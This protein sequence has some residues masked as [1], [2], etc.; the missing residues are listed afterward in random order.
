MNFTFN[1]NIF[2]LDANITFGNVDSFYVNTTQDYIKI[3]Y[4]SN[5]GLFRFQGETDEEVYNEYY[6]PTGHMKLK[7]PA[8][9]KFFGK[10]IYDVEL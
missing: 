2:D 9:H 10:P 7:S 8:E 5:G 1:P 3:D 6:C 4:D